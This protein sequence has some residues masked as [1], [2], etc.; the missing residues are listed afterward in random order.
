MSFFPV[1]ACLIINPLLPQQATC[2]GG[3]RGREGGTYIDKVC[4]GYFNEVPAKSV[5]ILLYKFSP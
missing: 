1:G 4:L 2:L 5:Q 3:G